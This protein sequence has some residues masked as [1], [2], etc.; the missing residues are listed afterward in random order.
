MPVQYQRPYWGTS[1]A[2]HHATLPADETESEEGPS[3]L[4]SLAQCMPTCFTNF[5]T[6]FSPTS[7]TKNII[8]S[9]MTHCTTSFLTIKTNVENA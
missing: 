3:A 5:L 2:F 4:S 9:I 8:F 7:C 6:L 1:W